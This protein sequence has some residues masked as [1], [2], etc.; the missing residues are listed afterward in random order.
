[1]QND[2]VEET[3]AETTPGTWAAV[4]PPN[5]RAV[6]RSRR[7]SARRRASQGSLLARLRSSEPSGAELND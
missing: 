5:I 6:R 4:T 7:K 2:T 1:M 3:L